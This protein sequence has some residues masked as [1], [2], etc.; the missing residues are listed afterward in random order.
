MFIERSKTS[1]LFNKLQLMKIVKIVLN[2]N[3]N[4]C[5]NTLKEEKQYKINFTNF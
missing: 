2:L 4:N 3:F 1:I 5:N